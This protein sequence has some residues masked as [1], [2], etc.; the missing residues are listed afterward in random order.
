MKD[1]DWFG[2]LPTQDRG[3]IIQKRQ[4]ISAEGRQLMGQY[5][6]EYFGEPNPHGYGG[7]SYDARF[8]PVVARMIDNYGLD[9]SSRILD[10]GCAK[11][12]LL[13]DIYNHDVSGVHGIDISEYA[14]GNV[15][16]EIADR[17]FVGSANDLSRWPDN[18][19]DLVISKD[20]LHNLPPGEADQ[21][22]REIVRV[23]RGASFIQPNSFV[24]EHQKA[25]LETWVITIK[26]VRSTQEWL[27]K[28]SEL[29]YSGDYHFL[30][31][32]YELK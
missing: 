8:G 1:I 29:G 9:S 5:G 11:G 16:R 10:V 2:S 31:H 28:F 24:T 27:D 18:Y 6:K 4:V 22:I 17:C 30:I 26:T 13:Y 12:F 3:K 23:G 15:P 21:A 25:C 19:F 14:I 20:A 7:Y 32:D